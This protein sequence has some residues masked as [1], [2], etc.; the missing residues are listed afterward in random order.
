MSLTFRRMFDRTTTGFGLFKYVLSVISDFHREIN[1]DILVLG[2]Y[3]VC[4][5][6]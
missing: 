1:T 6:N 5:V 2:F 4:R 3:T